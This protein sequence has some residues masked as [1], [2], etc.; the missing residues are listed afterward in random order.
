[1]ANSHYMD[2]MTAIATRHSIRRYKD[3]PIPIELIGKVVQ[4][5]TFAPT[6]GNIQDYR[7]IIVRDLAKRK[8]LAT[9]SLQQFWM[10]EAPVHIVVCN[11]IKKAKQYYGLRGERLYAVQNCAAAVENMLLAAHALG[12]ATCWVG[13]FDEDLVKSAIGIPPYARPHAI[14]TLGYPNEDPNPPLKYKLENITYLEGYYNRITNM[15][16]VL[17]EYSKVIEK[18]VKGATK[19]IDKHATNIYEKSK[20]AAKKFYDKLKG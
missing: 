15:P 20:H 10:E 12:L 6:S 8:A 5:G 16:V 3:I 2:T 11:E 17:G 4:A 19:H 13:G 9:A 1:M 18:T 7:F 14:V